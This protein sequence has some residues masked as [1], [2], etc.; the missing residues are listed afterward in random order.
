MRLAALITLLAL[1]SNAYAQSL[2]ES[3]NKPQMYRIEHGDLVLGTFDNGQQDVVHVGP[4]LY[5]NDPASIILAKKLE[6][7]K[8]EIASLKASLDATPPPSAP[9]WLLVSCVVLG[10]LLGG[11]AAMIVKR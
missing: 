9:A 3:A 2:E 5:L 8:A 6:G 10:V 11:S 7:D 1:G 4:G